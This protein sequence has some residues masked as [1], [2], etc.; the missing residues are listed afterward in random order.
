[1]GS[2][3]DTHKE[4]MQK[5]SKNPKLL[6]NE[7]FMMDICLKLKEDFFFTKQIVILSFVCFV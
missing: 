3:I 2:V 7:K 5:I 6:L 4:T 1:M